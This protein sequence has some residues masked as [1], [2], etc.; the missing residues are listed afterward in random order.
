MHCALLLLGDQ[1]RP[2]RSIPRPASASSLPPGQPGHGR[3]WASPAAAA[4]AA[5][6]SIDTGF[7]PSPRAGAG[8]LGGQLGSWIVSMSQSVTVIASPR[9]QA[10][11]QGP[12]AY[13]QLGKF[14]VAWR[15]FRAIEWDLC[16]VRE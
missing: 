4:G 2:R 10:S 14:S 3:L 13:L 8:E 7:V 1:P 12:E 11:L 6:A 9:Q 5:A 16:W 15:P